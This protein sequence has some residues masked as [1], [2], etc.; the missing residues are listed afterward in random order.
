MHLLGGEA[1]RVELVV[2]IAGTLVHAV[3]PVDVPFDEDDDDHVA[4]Q[5]VGE[6]HH[7]DHL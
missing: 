5:A 3:I 1:V 6:K 7:G 4:E 2:F